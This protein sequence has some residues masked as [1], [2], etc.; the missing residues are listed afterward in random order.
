MD[1]GSNR[2]EFLFRSDSYLNAVAGKVVEVNELG[3]ILL[4]RTN[5]YATSGGQPGDIGFLETASGDKI[6]IA[7][8]IHPDGDKN[9]IVHVPTDGQ[10]LPNVGDEVTCHIDWENRYKLMRMHTALHLLSV[11][12]PL[13]VTGGSIGAEKGRL[14]FQMPEP[15]EDKEALAAQLNAL[16]ERELDVTEEWI[17]EAELDANPDLVKT[18]AV[19]PPVGQGKIRMIRISDGAETVDWQPCGGTHVAN[20]REI[21]RMRF[22]K[23]EKKGKINRRVAIHFDS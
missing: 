1:N 20:T 2:T 22:G 23:V 14:D 21:G 18:M 13:P 6:K 16:I 17:T 4:D 3:G 19:K 12:I 9:L 8:T 15:P 7:T 5:F 10:D 11:V